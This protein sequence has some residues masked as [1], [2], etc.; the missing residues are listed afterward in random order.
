MPREPPRRPVLPSVS[1]AVQEGYR[2]S[3]NQSSPCG[4]SRAGPN[5]AGVHESPS[6]ATER[7][8]TARQRRA[9]RQRL[10]TAV[11]MEDVLGR[12]SC[13][14]AIPKPRRFSRVDA[15]VGAACSCPGKKNDQGYG[16]VVTTHIP[17][18]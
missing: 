1:T 5:V 13:G 9:D 11:R 15:R 7:A 12:I 10:Q 17:V 18:A 8:A 3:S 4:G 16:V 2:V 6:V 14:P